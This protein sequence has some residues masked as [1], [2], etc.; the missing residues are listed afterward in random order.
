MEDN[1]I[2]NKKEVKEAKK[3]KKKSPVRIEFVI[4]ISIII[5]ASMAYARFLL[6][7]NLRSVLQFVGSRVNEAEVNIGSIKTSFLNGSLTLSDIQI[8]DKDNP[9]YN[10][11]EIK[12]I[13]F[14]VMMEALLKAKFVV[15]DATIENIQ[16]NTKRD[17]V[18]KLITP[19][20]KESSSSKALK[21]TKASVL[22]TVEDSYS[23]NALGDIAKALGGV[24]PKD[25]IGDIKETLKSEKRIEELEAKVKEKESEW[26]KRIDNLPKEDEI[27]A[28]TNEAK[29]IKVKSLKDIKRVKELIK[30]AK[31]ISKSYSEANKALKTDLKFSKTGFKDIEKLIKKDIEDLEKR[32]SL[33]SVDAGDLSQKIFAKLFDVQLAKVRKYYLTAKKYMPPKKSPEEKKPSV[34]PAIR[35]EGRTY[36]FSKPG[37]LPLFWIK[38]V[39]LSS[40][41]HADSPKS[42]DLSG[43][44][45]NISSDQALIDKPT[46]LLISGDF[47]GSNVSGV[48]IK[49]LLDNRDTVSNQSLNVSVKSYPVSSFVLSKGSDLGLTME[50]SRGMA[51]LKTSL[52]GDSLTLD[53]NNKF[54]D[55]KYKV[56]A[57]SKSVQKTISNIINGIPTIDMTAKATGSF[58]KLDWS[59][60]SNLGREISKGVKREINQKIREAK[61]KIKEL[62]NER[63]GSK[64][65]KL[66]SKAKEVENKLTS[67]LDKNKDKL[68]DIERTL[69]QKSKSKLDSQKDKLKKKAKGLLK[70]FKF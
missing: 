42:G 65:E 27:K 58:D 16:I 52:I 61:N 38:N 17:K 66:L 15:D 64:K 51:S 33:P 9:E 46:D 56:E 12:K 67:I 53:L 30:K 23:E 36:T 34:A 62:V 59:I 6:D 5:I 50:K 10:S 55:N 39:D 49:G 31:S 41:S 32:F 8:T 70:K 47:P 22:S 54:N 48:E 18:G 20:H 35:A 1:K 24:N 4:P 29:N 69:A 19:D 7:G 13:N 68:I 11:L 63:V 40:K 60:R 28:L 26:K 37:G 25:Q 43:Y 21:K 57:K 14:D 2:D 3:V 45:K 44:I